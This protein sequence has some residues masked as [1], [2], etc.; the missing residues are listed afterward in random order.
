MVKP[1]SIGSRLLNNRYLPHVAYWTFIVVFFGLFWG[2]AEGKYSVLIGSELVLL[3]GKMAAVYLCIYWLVP[4]FLLKRR[5]IELVLLS[6]LSLIILGI[7]QR[8]LVYYILIPWNKVYDLTLPLFDKFQIMHLMVDINTVVVI[9]LGVTL[10]KVWY[11][12]QQEAQAL[13][14]EKLEA[15]LKFLKNQI[16]PHFLFNTLNNLYGLILKKSP[17]AEDVVLKLADLMRYM[18]YETNANTVPLEKEVFNTRSYIELEKVR[19]GNRVEVC[20]DVYGIVNGWE[21]APMLLLPFVENSFKHGVSASLER[22]WIRVELTVEEKQLTFKVENSVPAGSA[23][24]DFEV[25]S[26][27]GL[28]NVRRRLEILYPNGHK[29]TVVSKG[30]VYRCELMVFRNLA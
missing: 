23:N 15:E 11:K 30:G 2:S 17:Q 14:R 6:L 4:T 8:I 19:Y 26:G 3:P 16:Q 18:L 27:I 22:A 28:E 21:I 5:Y 10:V 24:T 25:P 1:F 9:P 7:F 13:E 20:F 12:K 29:L